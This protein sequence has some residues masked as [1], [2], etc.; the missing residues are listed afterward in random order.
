MSPKLFEYNG[1]VLRFYSN[2]H[3]SVHVHAIYGNTHGA[4]IEFL[5]Q[6]GKIIKAVF[7]KTKGYKMLEPAQLRDTKKL[8]SKYADVIVQYWIDYFV[9]NKTNITSKKIDKL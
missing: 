1:I 9:N 4:K 5:I 7:K 3:L 2:D 8:V 6:N